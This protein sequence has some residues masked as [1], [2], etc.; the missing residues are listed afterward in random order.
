[1]SHLPESKRTTPAPQNAPLLDAPATSQPEGGQQRSA[2]GFKLESS[3]AKTKS[4][5]SKGLPSE[6]IEGFQATTGVDLSEVAVHYDSP[7]PQ[8]V[9]AHAVADEEGIHLGAGQEGF[10][11]EEAA[12][13]VQQMQGKVQPTTTVNGTPVNHAASMEE[14][15]IRMGEAAKAIVGKQV[16]AP[17]PAPVAPAAQAPAVTQRAINPTKQDYKDYAAMSGMTL[18][19]LDKYAQTQADWHVSSTLTDAERDNIRQLLA[20]A[21]EPEILGPCFGLK[22]GD[23]DTEFAIS[24]APITLGFLRHY[25]QAVKQKPFRIS[26]TS[27]LSDA[28]KSGEVLDTL[29]GVFPDWVLSTAMQED[30]FENM[31]FQT[32]AADV[33]QYYTT[34]A[35]K[36]IFQAENGKDFLSYYRMRLLDKTNPLKYD[37]GVLHG[38]VRNFHRFHSE[39]LDALETNMA[40][41]KKTKPLLLILHSALDHNGAFHREDGFTNMVKDTTNNVIMLEGKESMAEMQGEIPKIAK[42]YGKNDKIDQVMIAGHGNAQ[43]MELAGKVEEDVTDHKLKEVGQG[44]EVQGL[45]TKLK[46]TL[47]DTEALFNEIFDNMDKEQRTWWGGK[48]D[49][50]NRQA[51]R[52]ILFNACLTGS[53]NMMGVNLDSSDPK[54]ARKTIKKWLKDNRN[55]VDW[56]TETAKDAKGDG[57]QGVGSVASYGTADYFNASGGLDIISKVDPKVTASKLVY[58]EEGIEPLGALR[59]VLE[60]WALDEA[61]T[62]AAMQRRVAK[63]ATDWGSAT[64]K[65]LYEMILNSYWNNGHAIK[66]LGYVAG[67]FSHGASEAH[68][69]VENFKDMA[70]SSTYEPLWKAVQGTPEW[71]S[72]DYIPLVMYQT[73]MTINAGAGADTGLLTQLETK[74][75]CQTASKYMDFTYLAAKGHLA[76]LLAGAPT[77]GKLMLALMA[78]QSDPSQAD[79]KAYLIAQLDAKDQFPA[80]L[81]VHGLLAGTATEDDILIAI[82]KLAP[83]PVVSAS[84]VVAPVPAVAPVVAPAGPDA[85]MSVQGDKQNSAR[86]QSVTKQGLIRE[87]IGKAF[88]DAEMTTHLGDLTF[89]DKVNIFGST[90]DCWAIE[91]N[92]DPKTRGSAFVAKKDILV[93]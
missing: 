66:I 60:S 55:L 65:G 5:T 40:D 46:G 26:A 77:K 70:E 83:P 38:Y 47:T 14:E 84:P 90:T 21:R 2:P 51:H 63:P 43:S 52:R 61:G 6:L 78:I 18:G 62:K 28:L 25:A 50:P 85:N 58:L 17:A 30:S 19:A 54:A 20:F 80:V 11:Y 93:S 91:Y 57:I 9:Q 68:C 41:T 16:Q 76:T 92:Y 12:H 36:P 82:G 73:W 31:K 67:K 75:D 10:L 88:K 86:V 64:I 74:F 34:A 29:K 3:P 23:L 15:A 45:D 56:T 22:V 48:K 79:A 13:K 32:N 7:K 4:K 59:A 27:T 87:P 49:N 39:A 72:R 35:F 44:V 8:Q 53:N 42:K 24:G 71:N 33:A 1:M 37:G 89:G 81:D 69:R